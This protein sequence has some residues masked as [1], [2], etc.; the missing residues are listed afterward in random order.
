MAP[1]SRVRLEDEGASQSHL[2]QFLSYRIARLHLAISAQAT[3]LLAETSGLSLGQWRVI[4]IVASG[5]ASTSRELAA[6][7]SFDPA[8]VS[9]TVS[10]LESE[11]LLATRRQQGDKRVLEL[12]LTERGRKLHAKTL[13]VMQARQD[14]LLGALTPSERKIMFKLIDK[15]ELAAEKREFTP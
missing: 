12:T 4:T 1:K 14:W 3:A 15:L 10:S 13:P 6:I 5:L 11:G 8:F 2:P 7:M 9:R